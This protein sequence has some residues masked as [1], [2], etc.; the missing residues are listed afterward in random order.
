MK[1]KTKCDWCGKVIYRYEYQIKTNK[2][3]FC[4]YKCV[5]KFRHKN[6]SKNIHCDYC[7]KIINRQIH[8]IKRNKY[9]FCNL[10]C[11]SKWKE[12][13]ISGKNNPNFNSKKLKCTYCR[14][15]IM[16]PKCRIVRCKH[17][18]CNR[19]CVNKYQ[20]KYWHGK[21]HPAYSGKNKVVQCSYCKRYL[22]RSNWILKKY[23]NYFCDQRCKSKFQTKYLTNKV[24][25]DYCNKFVII[26]K[27]RFKMKNRQHNFCSIKCSEKFHIGPNHP[28]W[29]DGSSFEPYTPEFNDRLK[30][31]IRDRDRHKCQNINCGIPE[32][33][34]RTKLHIHHIDYN[35]LNSDPINLIA[36]CNF[37][38]VRANS[39]RDYWKKYYQKIQIDRKVHE[40][41]RI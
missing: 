37:C 39:G 30:C 32:K 23:K 25:C 24:R 10:I 21:S 17:N 28:T 36:L 12:K 40:L 8:R 18:F 38:N 14:K 4:N 2:N 22:R 33:E 7:K 13:N 31:F 26:P 41:E 6:Y 16:R 29:Y 9:N 34:C 20:K 5:S 3:H 11:S 1:I 27:S 35:K 19:N 15:I